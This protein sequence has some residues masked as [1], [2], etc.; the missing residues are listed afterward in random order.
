MGAALRA[1]LLELTGLIPSDR[2]IDEAAD[3]QS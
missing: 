3:W 1:K 2:A